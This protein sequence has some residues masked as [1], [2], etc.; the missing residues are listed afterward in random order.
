MDNTEFEKIFTD[1]KV[2]ET[3]QDVKE[4]ET[5][6]Q[7]ETQDVKE[8]QEPAKDEKTSN[9]TSNLQ[10]EFK[11]L[12]K[13]LHDTKSWGHRKNAAYVNAKKKMGEFL[14]KL[15]ENSLLEEAE[16]SEAMGYFDLKDD[17]ITSS[18]EQPA[19]D[20]YKLLRDKLDQ[21]FKVFKKYAKSDNLEEKYNSFFYFFPLFAQEDQDKLVTYLANESADVALD[22]VMITGTE[23]YENLYEGAT[24]HGDIL[25]YLKTMRNENV[26]LSKKVKELESKLDDTTENFYNRSVKSR[27]SVATTD[28]TSSMKDIFVNGR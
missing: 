5:K 6:E 4:T 10:E 9:D 14:N 17:D 20:Q 3:P 16:V 25:E 7:E 24:K 27:G 23:L 13:R 2:I 11:T 21:E 15:C 1:N 18:E 19:V 26:K 8:I 12:Q 28:K 22:K